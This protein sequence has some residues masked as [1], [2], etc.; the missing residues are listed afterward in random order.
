MPEPGLGFESARS[1]LGTV[2][3]F[4][5]GEEV[6]TFN[7]GNQSNAEGGEMLLQGVAPHL[8]RGA[9]SCLRCRRESGAPALGAD[10]DF[11]KERSPSTE[12]PWPP[13]TEKKCLRPGHRA[14]CGWN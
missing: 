5:K 6:T 3:F 14:A 2:P 12:G 13:D 10:R 7:Q 9:A 1:G 4:F 8:L 11:R